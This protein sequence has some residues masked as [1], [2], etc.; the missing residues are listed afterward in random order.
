MSLGCTFDFC[1]SLIT[2]AD[3]LCALPHHAPWLQDWAGQVGTGLATELVL[4]HLLTVVLD[5]WVAVTVSVSFWS[6]NTPRAGCTGLL[7]RSV[8]SCPVNISHRKEDRDQRTTCDSDTVSSSASSGAQPPLTTSS[9]PLAKGTVYP[10]TNYRHL[11]QC[12]PSTLSC[13]P[14]Q[15]QTHYHHTNTTAYHSTLPLHHSCQHQ[16]TLSM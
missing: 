12:E 14:P 4:D 10:A 8:L 2:R 5:H 16:L 15:P 11:H 6:E 13:G 9:R 1:F 3:L 7:F